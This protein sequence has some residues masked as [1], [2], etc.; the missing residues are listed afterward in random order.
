MTIEDLR[1]TVDDF[2]DMIAGKPDAGYALTNGDILDLLSE[3]VARRE[4]D[5][6]IRGIHEPVEALHL[7]S[8]RRM[9]V[10]AGC[11]ADDGNWRPWPCPTIGALEAVNR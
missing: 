3:L 11:G 8:G 2:R 9:R 5:T 7:P 1:A 10:C 4:A 6:V